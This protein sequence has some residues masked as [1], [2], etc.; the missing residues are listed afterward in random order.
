MDS[1][2]VSTLNFSVVEKG[3]TYY[4]WEKYQ[5]FNNSWKKPSRRAINITSPSLEFSVITEEDEG[6]YRCVVTN[7]NG[8]TV[9]SEN[10]SISVYGKIVEITTVKY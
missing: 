2:N 7:A 3:P 5:P 6:V 9:V 1:T 8:D 10:A 4:Q